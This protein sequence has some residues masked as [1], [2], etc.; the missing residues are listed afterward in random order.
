MLGDT[1]DDL[2]AA[3]AAGVVP[4]GVV[5]P[6]EDAAGAA[7]T[8]RTAGAALVLERTEQIMEVLS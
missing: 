4:V 3:R 1:P 2:H 5:A 8:L 7:D 6:G